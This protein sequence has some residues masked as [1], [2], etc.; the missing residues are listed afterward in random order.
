M[1]FSNPSRYGNVALQ[2]G[3][4]EEGLAIN[5]SNMGNIIFE[6]ARGSRVGDVRGALGGNGAGNEESSQQHLHMRGRW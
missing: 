2:G 5:V 6:G 3:Q 1:S 4:W